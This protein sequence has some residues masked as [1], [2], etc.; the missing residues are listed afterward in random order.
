MAALQARSPGQSAA[1]ISC[2]RPAPARSSLAQAE[3]CLHRLV[4]RE[5]TDPAVGHHRSELCAR[6]TKEFAGHPPRRKNC[7]PQVAQVRSMFDELLWV[8]VPLEDDALGQ[9][10]VEV[11]GVLQRAGVLGPHDLHAL[12]GQA[13]ELPELAIV[14]H[15]PTDTLKLAHCSGL[16]T[17]ALL[18]GID[19]QFCRQAGEE[20]SPDHGDSRATE[21]PQNR[22]STDSRER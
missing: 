6:L 1:E 15:E 2:R 7:L 5:E 3:R 10:V 16:Q 9:L 18:T 12:S 11:N 13:I 22:S 4:G 20:A 14:K 8:P 19:A 21:A 17:P